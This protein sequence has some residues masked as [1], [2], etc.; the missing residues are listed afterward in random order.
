MTSMKEIPRC[1]TSALLTGWAGS[2]LCPA[3][4]W[5]SCTWRLL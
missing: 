5:R 1:Q 3:G 4:L 2:S